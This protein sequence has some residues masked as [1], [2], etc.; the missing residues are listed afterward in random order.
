MQ[1]AATANEQVQKVQQ[2]LQSV[3]SEYN[4]KTYE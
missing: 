3:E 1:K 2:K 4:L